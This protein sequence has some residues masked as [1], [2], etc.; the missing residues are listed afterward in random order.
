MKKEKMVKTKEFKELVKE[1]MIMEAYGACDIRLHYEQHGLNFKPRA[2]DSEIET[3]INYFSDM[4]T[5]IN[6]LKRNK[7][8][9]TDEKGNPLT[10]WGGLEEPKQ[11]EEMEK[12]NKD[13]I[14]KGTNYAVHSNTANI[15]NSSTLN[16]NTITGTAT[17]NQWSEP[18]RLEVNEY[19]EKIEMIFEETSLVALAVYPPRPPEK[20]YFKIIF[21]CVDGKWNKSE[22]IYGRK[23]ESESYFEFD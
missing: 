10:Y 1:F 18:I 5:K 9:Q 16:F 23:I 11:E 20:R 13:W 21:S 19:P 2:T 12:I 7:M 17:L 3:R 14:T 8:K 15:D 6:N 22:R 4:V